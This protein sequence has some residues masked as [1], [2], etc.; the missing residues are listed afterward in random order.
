MF[1]IEFFT[2]MGGSVVS[3]LSHNYSHSLLVQDVSDIVFDEAREL[4]DAETEQLLS[5][6]EWRYWELSHLPRQNARDRS[7]TVTPDMLQMSERDIFDHEAALR[8]A[9]STQQQQ[10]KCVVSLT[11]YIYTCLSSNVVSS[12]T[13][14]HQAAARLYSIPRGD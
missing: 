10:F 7:R 11:F 5:A 4:T 9:L 2:F 12:L 8:P 13:Q 6:L 14:S 1:L 3:R